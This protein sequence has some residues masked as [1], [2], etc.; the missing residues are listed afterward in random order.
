MKRKINKPYRVNKGIPTN[1]LKT[2]CIII[3]A[4]AGK[5]TEYAS[6]ATGIPFTGTMFV[7]LVADLTDAMGRSL[8]GDEAATVEA[9]VIAQTIRDNFRVDANFIEHLINTT[10]NPSLAA[11]LGFVLAKLKGKVAIAPI[12]VY[13]TVLPGRVRVVLASVKG[14][15]SYIVECSQIAEDGTVISVIEKTL[16]LTKGN[17]EGLIQ[18]AKYMFRAHALTTNAV[19]EVWTDY[20]V[21]RIS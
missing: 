6:L 8:A 19:G 15:H 10:N 1:S 12:S 20:V 21:L 18:G 5:L 2:L 3:L 16:P 4:M 11:K 17:I 9:L 14:A 7:A 13:N